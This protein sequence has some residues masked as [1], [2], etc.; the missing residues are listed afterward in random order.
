[1][2]VANWPHWERTL[3]EGPFMHHAG[4]IYGHFGAALLEACKYVDGL[5]PVSLT[6][7]ETSGWQ[8]TNA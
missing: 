8:Q 6:K 2:E 5:V 4:M 7:E 1:M 3:I